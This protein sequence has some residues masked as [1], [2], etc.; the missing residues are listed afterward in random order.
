M[1]DSPNDI[2]SDICDQMAKK[3][4]IAESGLRRCVSQAQVE[5]GVKLG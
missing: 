4:N 2:I 1:I 3:L 5:E